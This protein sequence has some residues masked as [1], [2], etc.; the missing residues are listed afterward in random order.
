M[1]HSVDESH[2]D[3]TRLGGLNFKT[4]VTGFVLSL[5]LTA[6]PFAAVAFGWFGMGATLAVVAV[7]A[8]VQ[9]L[10]HLFFFLHLDFSGGNAWNAGSGAF[11]VLILAVL[12]GGTLWLMYSLE[13]R[14]MIGG[15]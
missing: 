1:S 15:M 12:V 14:T 3:D 9:I 5:V 10:V 11:T 8:V 4:Y 13:M 2:H 6:I 7:T